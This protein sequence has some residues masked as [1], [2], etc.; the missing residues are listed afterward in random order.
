MKKMTLEQLEEVAQNLTRTE[1]RKYVVPDELW[2]ELVLGTFFE[3]EE[4]VFEL[5][6]PGE[7]PEDAKVITRARINKVSGEGEVEVFELQKK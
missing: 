1:L 3:A 4:T 5:Y 7:R 6:V 2:Q